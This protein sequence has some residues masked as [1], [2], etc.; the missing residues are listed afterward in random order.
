V[1]NL[2]TKEV[3]FL[4]VLFVFAFS[5]RLVYLVQLQETPWFDAPIED[6]GRY[7]DWAQSI[8]SDWLQMSQPYHEGPF[9]QAPLYPYLL[10]IVYTVLGHSYLAVRMIQFLLGSC[11]VLLIYF[12]GKK[13]FAGRSLWDADLFRGRASHPLVHRV[14]ESFAHAGGAVRGRETGVVEM[15]CLWGPDRALRH[16]APQ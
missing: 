1:R 5:L 4:I 12:L 8:Q 7:D 3:T 16:S 13:V 11:S 14:R 6:A 15:A 9:F 2:S 10:A